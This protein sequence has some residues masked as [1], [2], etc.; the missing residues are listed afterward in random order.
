[1]YEFHTVG[2]DMVKHLTLVVVIEIV[3]I[4]HH[5]RIK[6]PMTFQRLD[7]S[8]ETLKGKTFCFGPGKRRQTTI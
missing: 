3:D 7:L 8:L 5:L 2:I 1:M 6:I 4:G